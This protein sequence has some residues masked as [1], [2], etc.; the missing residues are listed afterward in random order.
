MSG[1]DWGESGNPG[2][3]PLKHPRIDARVQMRRGI[4]FGQ[5]PG[6]SSLRE[7]RYVTLILPFVLLL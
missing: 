7:L 2:A 5:T 4:K 1:G 3:W 6:N